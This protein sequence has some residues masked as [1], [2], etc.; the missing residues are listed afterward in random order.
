MMTI[1]LLFVIVLLLI[2]WLLHRESMA[3]LLHTIDMKRKVLE[4]HRESAN[5]AW[6]LL[7]TSVDQDVH[8]GALKALESTWRAIWDEREEQ[9]F[10]A[11]AEAYANGHR[12][13]K[14]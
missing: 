4:Y 13:A 2:A 1:W 7:R 12:D 10:K 11:L 6:S 8:R 5:D 3:D 9:H 14:L